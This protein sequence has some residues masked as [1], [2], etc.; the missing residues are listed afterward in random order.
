MND[1]MYLSRKNDIYEIFIFRK[2]WVGDKIPDDFKEDVYSRK[3]F[4]GNIEKP[5]GYY[6]FNS[7]NPKYSITKIEREYIDALCRRADTS[8]P[9]PEVI[10]VRDILLIRNGTC[11][12]DELKLTIKKLN[13]LLECNFYD[14]GKFNEHMRTIALYY[15][16]N[17]KVG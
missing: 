3:E 14:S 7:L 8:K 5:Y 4:I 9:M 2:E 6:V 17:V 15:N 12:F 11:S 1:M 16:H 10:T 13:G